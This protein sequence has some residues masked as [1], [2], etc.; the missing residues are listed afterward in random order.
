LPQKYR[1]ALPADRLECTTVT[2][3]GN[4]PQLLEEFSVD[5]ID[6]L[7]RVGRKD[8]HVHAAAAGK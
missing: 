1:E 8:Q 2:G 4:L 5:L 6:L 3:F 7:D